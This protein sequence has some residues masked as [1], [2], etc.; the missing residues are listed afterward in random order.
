MSRGMKVILYS[1]LSVVGIA[2]LLRSNHLFLSLE[3]YA[4][5][6]ASTEMFYEPMIEVVKYNGNDAII[7]VQED[8][9][10]SCYY[11]RKKYGVVW[12]SFSG[13]GLFREV[14]DLSEQAI[15]KYK[16]DCINMYEINNMGTWDSR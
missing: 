2:Y 8:N 7:Y 5:A 4:K 6:Q 12:H 16:Q 11:G 15:K 9:Y 13:V 3:S 14:D 1:T 10:V